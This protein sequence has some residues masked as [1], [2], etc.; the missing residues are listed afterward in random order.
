LDS[1]F[2]E[3]KNKYILFKDYRNSKKKAQ[4]LQ[5]AKYALLPGVSHRDPKGQ[6]TCC[7][8]KAGG[9]QYSSN[10]FKSFQGDPR[11][12]LAINTGGNMTLGT[13]VI[14]SGQHI[15]IFTALP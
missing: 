12:N 15:A 11:G 7:I 2:D 3:I 10:P 1:C 13:L 5:H 4:T 14:G 8:P 6:F 9:P